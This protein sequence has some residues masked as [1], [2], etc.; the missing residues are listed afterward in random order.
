MTDLSRTGTS[1]ALEQAR[2]LQAAAD[3]FNRELF[4][5]ALPPTMLRLERQKA[6]RG[7]YSPNKLIDEHGNKLDAITLNSTDA[8][9]RPLIELLSTLVHEQCHQYICRVI[10]EGAATGGH[11]VE[12]RQKMIELGLPPIRIG[13]TW[14][15]A[16]HSIYPDGAYAN[17]FRD[18][19][20][21][22][23][24]LPW[25]ELAKDAA[26]GR[27]RG[28]DK[29]RFQCPSCGSKAWARAAAE[30]LCGTCTTASPL[31]LIWMI[32]EVEAVGGGGKGSAA[33]ATAT[34]TDYPEPSTTPG[35]PV[36]TDE[37]GRALRLHCG[38]DHPPQTQID[39]LIVLV[40]GVQR[41]DPQLFDEWVESFSAQH[42]QGSSEMQ[43][44]IYKH[45]ARLLHPDSHPDATDK[46]REHLGEAFKCLQIA[47]RMSDWDNVTADDVRT[48]SAEG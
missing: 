39:A 6:S 40:F 37:L 38:I 31:N 26:R 5:G 17:C 27:A 1:P 32:P 10:N 12:W 48:A 45:R 8:A 43:K 28:L 4:D 3:I 24:R 25:Q 21:E 41:R 22:L 13:A 42:R 23:E 11:G 44:R 19:L 34:R 16:T 30:L 47:Y 14:R 29:V 46:E 36:W 35:L 15:Q 20:S 18:N 9:E 2:R 33:R 7:Y